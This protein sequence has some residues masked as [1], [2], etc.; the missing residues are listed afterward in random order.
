[1]PLGQM[2]TP[3]KGCPSGVLETG[4]CNW[5]VAPGVLELKL[6]VVVPKLGEGVLKLGDGV[7]KLGDGVLKLGDEVL[8][9]GE[10][11]PGRG[12]SLLFGTVV[13]PKLGV[14]LPKLGAAGLSRD[15]GVG[16]IPGVVPFG[17]VAPPLLNA[18]EVWASV[19]MLQRTPSA[20]A[21]ARGKMVA[22]SM[23]ESPL[24]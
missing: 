14:V 11:E 21:A 19:G 22:G 18:P 9:P 13:L 1:M 2:R 5:I 12:A 7:L 4:G 24:V 8:K 10:G 20:M 6:G 17:A 23:L 3:P 16:L 15:P